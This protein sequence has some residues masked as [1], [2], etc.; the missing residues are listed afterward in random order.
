ML[1]HARLSTFASLLIACLSARAM[2]WDRVELRSGEVLEGRLLR[3]GEGEVSIELASGGNVTFRLSVVRAVRRANPDGV[4]AVVYSADEAEGGPGG[5]PSQISSEA[6]WDSV[7]HEE[8][9]RPHSAK[10]SRAET[11]LGAA[12]RVPRRGFSVAP[13]RSLAPWPEG[14]SPSVPVAYRD[15]ATQAT[16]TASTRASSDPIEEVKQAAVRGYGDRF[17]SFHVVRDERLEP[18]G[19]QEASAWVV[20][21]EGKAAGAA[22]RQL[23]VFLKNGPTIVTLTYSCAL[24]HFKRLSEAFLASVDSFRFEEAAKPGK[25]GSS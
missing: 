13:P 20:E 5:R 25:G 23:Q 19:A 10:P 17:P 22:V 12:V 11:L 18:P 21:I 9:L 3:L 15:P 2:A 14:E 4:S 1:R 24:E 7:G 6:R 16:F 8:P